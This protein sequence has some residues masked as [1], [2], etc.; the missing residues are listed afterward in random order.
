MTVLMI[1][2]NKDIA[3]IYKGEF[4][5]NKFDVTL[6][7][8]GKDGMAKAQENKYDV[9]LLDIMLPDMDGLDILERIRKEGVNKETVI[10]IISNVD[11]PIAIEKAYKLGI[12]GYLIKSQ[13]LPPQIVQEVKN[14]LKI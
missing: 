7:A 5:F 1:E 13:L 6:A 14:A 11:V 2:D 10:F 3:I 12:A 9:I 8:T 4:E